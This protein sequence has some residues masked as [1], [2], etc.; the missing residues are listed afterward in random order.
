MTDSRYLDNA[1]CSW[2][3]L[4]I[5][6]GLVDESDPHYFKIDRNDGECPLAIEIDTRRLLNATEEE[7]VA[8]YRKAM[9]TALIHAGRKY[10]LPFERLEILLEDENSGEP[11]PGDTTQ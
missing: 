6:K 5:R 8:V 11:H 10:E 3:G 4:S 1:P 9:L 2:I 7:M